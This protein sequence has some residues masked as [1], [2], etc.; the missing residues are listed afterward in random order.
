MRPTFA[1]ASS[2]HCRAS[3]ALPKTWFAWCAECHSPFGLGAVSRGRVTN[4]CGVS[5]TPWTESPN[6]EVG[7]P[8]S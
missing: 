2:R 1:N 8:V 6:T 7:R 5:G 4:P 3:F